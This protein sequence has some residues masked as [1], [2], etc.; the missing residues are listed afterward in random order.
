[1]PS[2][3]TG[4]AP[5][6]TN[7]GIDSRGTRGRDRWSERAINLGVYSRGHA[8]QEGGGISRVQALEQ[9][10]SFVGV[11]GDEGEGKP[12]VSGHRSALRDQHRGCLT[13]LLR[14]DHH[15][16]FP[17]GD[18][19]RGRSRLQDSSLDASRTDGL[20]HAI[21]LRRIVMR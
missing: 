2:P 8:R 6:S 1:M 11:I 20:A 19:H 21:C 9:P 16:P 7:F 15:A 5:V 3:E 13:E 17:S 10:R 14:R 18:E 4:V 12:F